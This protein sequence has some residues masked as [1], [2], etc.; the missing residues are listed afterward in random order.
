MSRYLSSA[1]AA[2]FVVAV[3]AAPSLR[4]QQ[5]AQQTTKNPHIAFGTHFQTSERCIACHNGLTAATGEDISIGY[6]SHDAESVGLYFV[7]SFSFRVAT[8]EAAV[9]L[10][11]SKPQRKRR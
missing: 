8:P 5:Q 4:S 11:S 7:D 10:P 6:E 3:L 9:A 2:A 1:L